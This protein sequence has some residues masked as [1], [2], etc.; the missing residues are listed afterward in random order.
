[1]DAGIKQFSRGLEALAP[2]ARETAGREQ[3][4]ED[5]RSG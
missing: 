1:M 5:R 2:E 3:D 4:R